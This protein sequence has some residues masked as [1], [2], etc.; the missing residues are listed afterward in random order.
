MA[1]RGRRAT[2]TR[3]TRTKKQLRT[4]PAGVCQSGGGN[5]LQRPI[6][7]PRPIKNRR[8]SEGIRLIVSYVSEVSVCQLM[9]REG[10]GEG[11]MEGHRP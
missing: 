3:E 7:L 2:R 5:P 1:S 9:S 11:T 6:E 4:G 8:F 10:W